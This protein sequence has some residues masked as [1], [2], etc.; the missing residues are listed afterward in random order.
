MTRAD[1]LTTQTSG[2][3]PAASSAASTP[4]LTHGGILYTISRH[5][6]GMTHDTASRF[7]EACARFAAD[8]TA[9]EPA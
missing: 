3:E 1:I 4:S 8:D 5:K 6:L 9:P 7:V 2:T